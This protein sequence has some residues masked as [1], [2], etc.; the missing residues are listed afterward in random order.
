MSKVGTCGN[1]GGA[2]TTPTPTCVNCGSVPVGAHGPVL[3]MKR[4]DDSGSVSFIA[5]D[6]ATVARRLKES[7][8]LTTTQT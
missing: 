3:P 1:C 5:R 4:R 6:C 7:Y 2:V 8:S